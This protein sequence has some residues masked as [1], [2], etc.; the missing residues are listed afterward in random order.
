MT[1]APADRA[2]V[3][4]LM[5]AQHIFGRLDRIISSRTSLVHRAEVVKEGI[6]PKGATGYWDQVE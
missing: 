1:L 4:V 5:F 3:C 6:R 2:R